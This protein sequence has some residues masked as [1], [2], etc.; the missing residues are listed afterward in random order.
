MFGRIERCAWRLVALAAMIVAL[1]APGAS[2]T[3]QAQEVFAESIDYASIVLTEDDLAAEGFEGYSVIYSNPYGLEIDVDYL[4]RSQD[5]DA[6]EVEEVFS[7]AGYA[8]SYGLTWQISA[9]EDDPFAGALSQILTTA[10]IFEDADGAEAAFELVTDESGV[11]VVEDIEDAGDSIGDQSE[12]S[13]GSYVG[14]AN[15]EP[16]YTEIELEMQLDRLILGVSVVEFAP[17]G[18]EAPEADEGAF[19][20]VEALGERL[21]ERAEVALEGDGPSLLPLVIKTEAVEGELAFVAYELLDGE[22][23]P[24]VFQDIEEYELLMEDRLEDGMSSLLRVEQFLAARTEETPALR[25]YVFLF[26]FE[27]EGAAE[28]YMASREED[29]SDSTLNTDVEAEP[30]D[31]LGDEAAM[32]TITRETDGEEW[33]YPQVFTRVGSTVTALVIQRDF[34]DNETAVSAPEEA[35]IALAELQVDC[36]EEG[37]CDGP[38]TL[39]DEV[40]EFVEDLEE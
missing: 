24:S 11:S 40:E 15:D 35:I 16:A 32:V 31:G 21:V 8:G 20:A 1:L 23:L 7:D 10:Y 39:P 33:S 36:I 17:G 34:A 6:D 29:L 4:S 3:A 28:G 18:D 5:L 19:P 22:G 38:I 25:L 27:D 37:E 12:L 26:A 14:G 13:V 2:S 9:D 30:V